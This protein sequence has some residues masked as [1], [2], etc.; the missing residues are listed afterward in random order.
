MKQRLRNLPLL[1]SEAAN[2]TDGFRSAC[3]RHPSLIFLD[4]GMPGLSGFELLEKLK[5]EP[6]VASIPVV[7]VTASAL[8]P[9]DLVTIFSQ[10]TAGLG[11]S[12]L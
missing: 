4:L 2:G 1:I 12:A 6:G 11:A 5:S 3:K 7:I 8:S 10:L 9:S